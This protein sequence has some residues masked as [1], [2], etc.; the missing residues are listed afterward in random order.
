MSF[1]SWLSPKLDEDEACIPE[2]GTGT[3]LVRDDLDSLLQILPKNIHQTLAAHTNRIHLI[4][5]IFDLGR[6]P[7]A[8]FMGSPGGEYLRDTEVTAEELEAAE[9]AVGDFG[10]DNRAGVAGTLHRISALR[11]RRGAVI[12]LTCRVGRAVSGHT[13]MLRD[14]V[15]SGQ[16]VLL[17]GRPGVGKTTVVR[18][19]A[20]VLANEKKKRV[21]I[22]D[23]SNEIG[24]DGD[25]AHPAIGSARRMQVAD[26]S[27]QHRVMIEA[28][29]NHM[30]ENVTLSDLIGGIQ[31]V[32][33]GDEE[34]RNRGTRK[35]VLERRGP[36]TFPIVVEIRDRAFYVA[37]F[38]Q[39]SVDALLSGKVPNVQVRERTLATQ[40]LRIVEMPYDKIVDPAAEWHDSPGTSSYDQD[41]DEALQKLRSQ[42]E[43]P[44]ASS[45][46]QGLDKY[47]WAEKLNKT[48]ATTRGVMSEVVVVAKQASTLAL[49]A[50]EKLMV[51]NAYSAFSSMDSSQPAGKKSKAKS[52][53]SRK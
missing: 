24:G 8:R 38:T 49:R 7:E 6:R 11:S 45:D 28:V 21:V 44:G 37:H 16:S 29:E 10:S 48:C 34:A 5:V 43:G 50:S 47:A 18:E 33:L 9:A 4:E 30:P 17:L 53:S 15:E 41:Y 2:D 12:G 35:T 22:V 40:E 20:R 25:V 42:A 1:R 3:V 19:I 14:L 52:S 39:D 26:A 23:T 51:A 31:T 46:T 36:P 32:T 13:D 27:Q